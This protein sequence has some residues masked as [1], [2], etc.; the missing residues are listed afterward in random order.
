MSKNCSRRGGVSFEV[1][2]LSVAQSGLAANLTDNPSGPSSE[3][4]YKDL[5][6]VSMFLF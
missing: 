4:S 6:R 2:V 3:G 5:Q 1:T